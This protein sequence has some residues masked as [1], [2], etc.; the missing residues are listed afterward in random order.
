[1]F[2]NK[3]LVEWDN[4]DVCNWLHSRNLR[5]HIDSFEKSNLTGYDL[6][7]LTKE[8]IKSEFKIMSF[9]ERINMIK[10]I[11]KLVVSYCKVI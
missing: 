5:H 11:R 6:C 10:E 9:H 4:N 8:E 2:L 7:Y 1:M 3:D